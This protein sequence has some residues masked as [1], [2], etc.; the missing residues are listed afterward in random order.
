[1]I[2]LV[3]LYA[4]L[5]FVS[6]EQDITNVNEESFAADVR[7]FGC[8]SPEYVKINSGQG[9]INCTFPPSFKA[10][11]WYD[12]F[13]NNSD[14]P[15]LRY[16]S[17]SGRK[18]GEGY[19]KG[20][21][22]VTTNGSL[23]IKKVTL[24]HEKSFKVICIEENDNV[25]V[26]T[27]SV[28]VLIE[29]PTSQLF[30]GTCSG[31]ICYQHLTE[32]T[33]L[34]CFFNGTKPARNV[35]WQPK[36]SYSHNPNS[37]QSKIVEN[38]NGTFN[39]IATLELTH[40]KTNLLSFWVCKSYWFHPDDYGKIG[41][42]VDFSDYD[43]IKSRY[44][45]Q[46]TTAEI[47]KPHKLRCSYSYQLNVWKK[48]KDGTAVFLGLHAFGSVIKNE[49]YKDISFTNTGDIEFSSIKVT[50]EGLYICLHPEV[51]TVKIKGVY[52]EVLGN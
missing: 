14:P 10:V 37:V 49:V 27:S 36:L 40:S 24:E 39:S 26:Y 9:I 45:A 35:F 23:V 34:S 30:I 4:L 20:D 5:I 2:L 42:L 21:Y 11:F 16:D 13:T 44:I 33:G 8:K 41:I 46:N 17:M 19:I 38:A 29:S 48:I 50:H 15:V 47:D 12:V 3:M 43:S 25:E 6:S 31:P 22:D 28:V 52:V 32:T 7:V 1:M 51:T 18:S